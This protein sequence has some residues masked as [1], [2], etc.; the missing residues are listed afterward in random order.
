MAHDSDPTDDVFAKRFILNAAGDDVRVVQDALQDVIKARGFDSE[1]CFAIR[2]ALE[3]A[4][5]NAFKHGNKN[6]PKKV[7]I[8]Q[9]TVDRT[10]VILEIE[11]EGM[12][13]DPAVVPDPIED[14]NIA[15]PCG[16][17]IV[18]MKAFMSEI[19]FQPPGNRLRM[20]FVRPGNDRR[21]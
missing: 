4:L 1:C 16:R 8:L 21:G 20:T 19:E 10:R 11:D 12:G 9:S 6:D 2:L 5:S 14:E 17:G 7:V 15:I 3:E 18:L 13:F